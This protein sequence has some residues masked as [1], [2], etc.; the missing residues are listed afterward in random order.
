[1]HLFHEEF[2]PSR[3]R[4]E[5]HKGFDRIGVWEVR[6]YDDPDSFEGLWNSRLQ[7]YMFRE[8][9]RFY[10]CVGSWIFLYNKDGI[11]V[12]REYLDIGG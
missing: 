1:M 4:E 2:K 6:W 12:D 11:L 3:T 5:I 9:I 10:N 8:K 7:Q